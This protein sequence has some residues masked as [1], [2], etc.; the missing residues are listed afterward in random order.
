[1]V[2]SAFYKRSAPRTVPLTH[3]G[4]SFATL[5][6]ER[7]GGSRTRLLFSFALLPLLWLGCQ[8][9]TDPLV[10]T[11]ADVAQHYHGLP[12]AVS[13]LDGTLQ[14]EDGSVVFGYEVINTRN[15]P[16]EGTAACRFT[17]DGTLTEALIDGVALRGDRLDSLT[18]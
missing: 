8:A 12:N 13:I 3:E 11:C 17:D 4:D 9:P 2:A 15:Q 14:V 7:S 10:A 1:C 16:Q 6:G 18:D 5:H